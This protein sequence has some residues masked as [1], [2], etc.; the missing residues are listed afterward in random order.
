MFVILFDIDGTLISNS[1]SKQS[2][3]RRFAEAIRDVVGRAP[4]LTLRNSRFPDR[5]SGMV[6]PQISRILLNQMGLSEEDVKCSLPRVIARMG[7]R[8]K[9][10]EK[11]IVLNKGVEPLLRLLTKSPNHVIG[12]VTGN[13]LE[14]GSEKLSVTGIGSYFSERFYGDKYFDRNRLVRAAVET[15]VAKHHLPSSHNVVIVGDTLNDVIAANSANATSIGVA[16]G[17]LSMKEL[18]E[19]GATSV[20]RDLKPTKK[21]LIALSLR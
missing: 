7:E 13:I 17:G 1:I 21:L 5:F 8:Y 15:C 2:E 18:S 16:S 12:V 4:V 10:L 11:Q 9:R 3:E 20:F 19:A 6:D 14:V